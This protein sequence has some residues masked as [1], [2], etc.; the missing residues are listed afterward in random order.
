MQYNMYFVNLL[1]HIL[2]KLM[3]GFKILI[4]LHITSHITV[5]LFEGH[6]GFLDIK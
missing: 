4:A 2:Q 1:T 5:H 3:S 6:C